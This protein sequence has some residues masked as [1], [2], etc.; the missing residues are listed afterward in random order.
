MTLLVSL[1]NPVLLITLVRIV[2]AGDK[3][4]VSKGKEP[5]FKQRALLSIQRGI[6]KK[7]EDRLKD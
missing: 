7:F 4:L 5:K 3:I 2:E 6:D 1:K